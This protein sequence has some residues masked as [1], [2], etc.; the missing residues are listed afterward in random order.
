MSHKELIGG[1]IFLVKFRTD[2]SFTETS[3]NLVP[4]LGVNNVIPQ[5]AGEPIKAVLS[6]A[7][8]RDGVATVRSGYNEGENEK[9][10]EEGNENC[11][12]TEIE[13]QKTLLVPVGSDKATE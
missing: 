10:E 13:G 3:S 11:H 7:S 5:P 1:D 2:I 4:I 12:E 9:N 6:V 8:S